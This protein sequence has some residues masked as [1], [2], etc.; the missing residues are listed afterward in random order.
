MFLLE[1]T[2]EFS[3]VNAMLGNIFKGEEC[4]IKT[5]ELGVSDHTKAVKVVN[6]LGAWS[7]RGNA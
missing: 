2:G 5:F 6:L 4:F 7:I 1:I 3:L